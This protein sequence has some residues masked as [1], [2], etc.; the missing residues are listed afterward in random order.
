MDVIWSASPLAALSLAD[1]TLGRFQC[2]SIAIKNKG[3]VLTVAMGSRGSHCCSR[4][5]VVCLRLLH[6]SP[7]E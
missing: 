5:A 4:G 6:C 1:I 7:G 2:S 3:C